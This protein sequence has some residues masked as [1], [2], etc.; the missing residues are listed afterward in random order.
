MIGDNSRFTQ[1]RE[2]LNKSLAECLGRPIAASPQTT[3]DARQEQRRAF[4]SVWLYIFFLL[5]FAS[6]SLYS[7][8]SG[9]GPNDWGWFWI[10]AVFSF[11]PSALLFFASLCSAW[12]KHHPEPET[13]DAS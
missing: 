7:A 6:A 2:D 9:F 1:T 12:R 3:S 11:L 4:V 5:I 10:A 13:S 8:W